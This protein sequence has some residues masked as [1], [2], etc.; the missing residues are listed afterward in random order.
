MPARPLATLGLLAGSLLVALLIGEL[1]LRALGVSYYWAVGKRP[2][3]RLGWRP[4]AN[5]SA[6]QRIEGDALVRTNA[7]GFRDRDHPLTK[8]AGSLRIAVLGDSMTEAVQVPVESTWWR[9]MAGELRDCVGDRPVEVLNFGVSGY[10]TAQQ[11]LAWR[12]VASRYSP[13]LVVLGF[14]QGNDLIES[15]PALDY[16][17]MRPYFRLQGGELQPDRRFLEG[18]AY[19]SRTSWHGR[20]WDALIVR[21]R[22]L[23][24]SLEARDRWRLRRGG[25]PTQSDSGEPFSEP[26]VDNHIYRPPTEAEWQRAWEVV[27]ALLLQLDREVRAADADLLVATMT[28]G[29]QVHPSPRFSRAYARSLELPDLYYPG[30]RIH[31][32]GT[33][34]DLRTI[35]LAPELGSIAAREGLFLHG[36]AGGAQGIGHW[37]PVG[38]A[39][40]GRAIAERLCR[41]GLPEST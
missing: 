34:H 30:W 16:D 24:A 37:N 28:T 3:A 8:P 6:R 17:D 20:L 25:L 36:F 35:D 33:A 11:L 13:D 29:A 4:A 32:L 9:V 31:E 1:A 38:H 12:H 2:D 26:G 21:S 19:R 18:E 23:Q 7:E 39:L 27:E 40:A 41:D 14:Y 10:G 22:L 5:V 15:T